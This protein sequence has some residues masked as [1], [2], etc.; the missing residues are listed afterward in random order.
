MNT[1]DERQITI[2][3][4]M[5][6]KILRDPN[7]IVNAMQ[8]IG[9]SLE[10]LGATHQDISAINNYFQGMEERLKNNNVGFW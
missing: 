7:G 8:N 3:S 2:L 10:E 5:A 9:E 4:D 1:L 6:A